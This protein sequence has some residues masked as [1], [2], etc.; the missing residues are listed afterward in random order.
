MDNTIDEQQQQKRKKLTCPICKC[1][2]P[3]K[4]FY[5]S[6]HVIEA[7]RIVDMLDEEFPGYIDTL[8]KINDKKKEVKNIERQIKFIE[9]T[10]QREA[11]FRQEQQ[12]SEIKFIEEEQRRE[13]K[14]KRIIEE[15]KSCYAAGLTPNIH[16][17]YLLVSED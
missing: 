1:T 6:H 7:K 5:D 17:L 11:K 12:Q 2:F 8:S 4:E 16:A 13:S 10:M 15:L 9:E 3:N 14:N